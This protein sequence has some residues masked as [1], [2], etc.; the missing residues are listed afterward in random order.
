MLA[1]S[2]D[3][4]NFRPR[5]F[6]MCIC[7][8]LRRSNY[9]LGP[10]RLRQTSLTTDPIFEFSVRWNAR[11]MGAKVSALDDSVL[12]FLQPRHSRTSAGPVMPP[13]GLPLAVR[14][15]ATVANERRTRYSGLP[16]FTLARIGSRRDFR[17]F[18]FSDFHSFFWTPARHGFD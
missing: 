6:S 1:A 16:R 13:E 5:S 2:F 18:A 14:R 15:V 8:F 12:R 4:Q 7:S 3:P 17:R 10:T 11:R 9:L